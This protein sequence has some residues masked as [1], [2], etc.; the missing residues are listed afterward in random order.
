MS[1][2]QMGLVCRIMPFFFVAR[3]RPP[4]MLRSAIGAGSGWRPFTSGTL[5]SLA[6]SCPVRPRGF[7]DGPWGGGSAT[8]RLV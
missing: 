3:C 7:F 1:P 8:R 4:G 2:R 6:W 5:H